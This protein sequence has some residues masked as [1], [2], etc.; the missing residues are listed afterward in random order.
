MIFFIKYSK[1]NQ[2]SILFTRYLFETFIFPTWA[3]ISPLIYSNILGRSYKCDSR[4]TISKFLHIFVFVSFLTFSKSEN[5][6][7]QST[8][9]RWNFLSEKTEGQNSIKNKPLLMKCEFPV[10]LSVVKVGSWIV[11]EGFNCTC[12]EV[13]SKFRPKIF[14]SIQNVISA[15]GVQTRKK[16]LSTRKKNSYRPSTWIEM[17]IGAC[18]KPP[19][20][21]IDM[22]CCV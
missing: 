17:F 10:T 6:R 7:N 5:I 14:F 16:K 1:R 18:T 13:N 8:L 21:I 2:Y 15:N 20:I 3:W 9:F 12:S 11:F 22:L 19:T 4:R